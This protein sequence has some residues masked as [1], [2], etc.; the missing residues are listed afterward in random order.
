MT[1]NI[2]LSSVASDQLTEAF[3]Y[4]D[5]LGKGSEFLNQI[6]QVF[7]LISE[8]PKL[9]PID[10]DIYRRA[11]VQKFPYL[12]IYFTDVNDIIVTSVFNTNQN[13]KNRFP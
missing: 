8:N 2:N 4:Y 7:D 3:L 13:P 9:F 12:I 5:E 10:F 11:T 1:F 6:Y